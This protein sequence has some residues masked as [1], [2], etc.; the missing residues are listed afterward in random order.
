MKLIF[1]LLAL[2]VLAST[3]KKDKEKDT[4]GLLK[5]KVIRTSCAGVVVQVLNDDTVGEDGWKDMMNKDA[6]YDNVFAVNNAC[7]FGESLKTG[8]TIRF[9]ID[10]NAANDC[11]FCMMYDGL[12][13]ANNLI[14][15]VSVEEG[16]D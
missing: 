11:A 10:P 8:K 3:C 9:K 14:S 6:V 5:G 2:P 12:P 16:K 1:I 15:E 13:K 7:K 4:S